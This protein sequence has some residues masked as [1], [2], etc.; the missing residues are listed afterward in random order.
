M[1][2]TR[3]IVA[4]VTMFAA[5][6]LVSCSKKEPIKTAEEQKAE[7]DK[8]AKATRE[9]AVFGEQVKAMDKAKAVT[10]KA[11]ELQEEKIKQAY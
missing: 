4:I 7:F 6:L 2:K 9:N 5:F 8:A 11:N 1:V 10:E 3:V